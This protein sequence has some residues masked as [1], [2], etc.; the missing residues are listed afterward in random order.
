MAQQPPPPTATI[1]DTRAPQP[2][3]VLAAA[4]NGH[5]RLLVD[6]RRLHVVCYC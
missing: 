6:L 4:T 1:T 2:K 5:S 3:D